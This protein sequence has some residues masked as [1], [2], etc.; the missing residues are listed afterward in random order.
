MYVHIYVCTYMHACQF[1]ESSSLASDTQSAE[2][3]YE[4][5]NP[6]AAKETDYP[7]VQAGGEGE[8]KGKWRGVESVMQVVR[9]S[10]CR[11]IICG[12][13]HISISNQCPMACEK[14]IARSPPP[15]R[16]AY[17]RTELASRPHES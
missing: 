8:R 1:V 10:L 3:R 13:I 9:L 17:I 5:C 11:Q 16:D 7:A 2:C 4:Q 15:Y 6:S 14:E 12:E